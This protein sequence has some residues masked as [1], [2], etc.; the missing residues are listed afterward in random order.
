[1]GGAALDRRRAGGAGKWAARHFKYYFE[2]SLLEYLRPPG[3]CPCHGSE[4]LSG[5]P[6]VSHTTPGQ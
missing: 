1:M 6:M 2:N 4:R 3:G 5:L